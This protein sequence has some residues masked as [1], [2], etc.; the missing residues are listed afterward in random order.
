MNSNYDRAFLWKLLVWIGVC[1]G[2]MKA[3]GGAAAL[4]FPIL[5]LFM[6]GNRKPTHLLFL[7]LMMIC[8]QIGNTFFFPK[9]MLFVLSVRG[10]LLFLALALASQVFGRQQSR[11]LSPLGGIVAY[12]AWEVVSSFQGFAPIISYLKLILFSLIYWAY[13]AVTNIVIRDNRSDTTKI[14]SIV[15]AVACLFLLGSILVMPFPGISL[16]TYEEARFQ[17]LL[18]SLFKGMTMHSQ[19]LGP[20][21]AMFSALILADLLFS[22]RKLNW[23]YVALLISAPILVFKT[24][25]RTALA[26]YLGSSA[27]ILFLFSRFRGAG[28]R[29]KGKVYNLVFLTVVLGSCLVLAIPH[30]RQTMFRFVMKQQETENVIHSQDVGLEG[31]V[32]SRMGAVDR[33]L[34]YFKRKP[35]LGNGFQVSEGMDRQGGKGLLS[36]LSAP[37][38][39]GVWVTAVLEEGGIVGL[40]LFAGFLIYAFSTLVKRGAY[41]TASCLFTAALSNMGEFTFFSMTYTGGL[42]WAL[43]FAAVVLD[44]QR[45][46]DEQRTRAGQEF[47]R[48]GW[49]LDFQRPVPFGARP[50]GY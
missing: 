36:Y 3:S 1:A 12:L 40:F 27:M 10:T 20:I 38:E 31:I 6:L 33:S 34:Y 19:S 11:L 44:H 37:I 35:F 32:A 45:L 50:F 39:K 17:I 4:L 7:L 28:T 26:T 13:Y 14:R 46:R 8:A 29:W 2:L 41:I 15:L 22:V 30:Y 49:N 47:P 48:G 18:K 24:S 16:M 23:L 43:V 25:S 5:A 9:S 42:V 21:A